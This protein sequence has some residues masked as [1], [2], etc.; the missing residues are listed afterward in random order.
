MKSKAGFSSFLL[1]LLFACWL[2]AQDAT[3]EIDAFVEAEMSRQKIPGISLAVVKNGAPL[4]VKGYGFSNVEHSVSVKPETIFQSGS[5]GKQFTAFAVM[6]LIEEGKASLDD[7]LLKH[8]PD[9][10]SEWNA[11]TIRHLLT[12]TAGLG[13][14]PRDFDLQ[15]DATEAE[16]F[17][18]LQAVK[19]AAAPGERWAYSN[20]GYMTLGVLI[21]K[22]SGKFYADFLQERVFKPLG[23]TTARV[24]SE[25]DIVANRAAG[26]ILVNGELKNQTWVAPTLNTT[27]DGALY[28]TALDMVKW[29]GALAAGKLLSKASYEEMWKPVQ[30]NNGSKHP[31][32]FG[33]ALSSV[34]QHRIIEHSGAWQGFKAHIARF[35]DKKLTV[36]AFANL[37]QANPGQIVHGIARIIDPELKPKPM[38]DPDPAHTAQMKVLLQ[39]VLDKKVDLNR[40]TAEM[41]TAIKD[42]DRLAELIKALGAMKTFAFMDKVESP[43]AT[44]FRYKVEYAEMN[45]SLIIVIDKAGKIAG[46]GLQP[47]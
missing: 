29:E 31:Y 45:L 26:Y 13:D 30:L 5:V 7:K 33:W 3:R 8:L 28:L 39:E 1:I 43:A 14:Y 11:I 37:A 38:N 41:Q 16:I 42:S 35:P 32:G 25:R 34:N 27:A 6:M 46:F 15:R 22:V 4:L 21:R 47:E 10:P 19:P 36:I 9:I 12:H 23:M 40:F 2:N 44:R 24:I 18:K 17:K 20:V